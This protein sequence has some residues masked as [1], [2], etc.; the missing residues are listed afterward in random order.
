M[1]NRYE[2]GSVVFGKWSI[3]RRIGAGS[4]GTVYEIRREEFDQ[5]YRAALK[6][7]T[8]PQNETELQDALDEGMT[9]SR[10]ENYFYFVVKD[11]SR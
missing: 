3:A 4:F 2:T 5:V 7:I 10:V 9:R 8:V 1:K 11:A 6:V